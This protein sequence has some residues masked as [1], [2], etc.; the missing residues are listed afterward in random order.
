MGA[1]TYGLVDLLTQNRFSLKTDVKRT[2]HPSQIAG[3][4]HSRRFT[5]G[6]V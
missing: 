6:M 1:P 2:R 3:A 4:R 5:V